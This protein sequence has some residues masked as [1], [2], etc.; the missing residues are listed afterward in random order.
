MICM[1]YNSYENLTFVRINTENVTDYC[2]LTQ[3]IET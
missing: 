3:E 1:F 2:Y